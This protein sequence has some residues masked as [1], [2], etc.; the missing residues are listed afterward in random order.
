MI[1]F[2]KPE[3]LRVVEIEEPHPT[4]DEVLIAVRA[5]GVNPSDIGNLAGRFPQ[6]KLPRTPGRDY[7]GV[8]VQGPPELLGKEVWGTGGELGFTRDG[9]HA[10]YV[11][12]PRGAVREKPAILSMEQAAGIG[13]PFVTAWLAVVEAAQVTTGETFVV[14]GS[15]GSVGSAAVQIARW[16]GARTIGVQRGA[17]GSG[18]DVVL[19]SDREDVVKRILELTS[20]RGADACLDAVGG[21]LFDIALASLARGGRLAAI[22]AKGDGRVS[23]DLRD[24]YHRELRLIGVDSLKLDTTGAA[25]VLDELRDG[26]TSLAL[27]P[28]DIQT[29]PLAQASGAYAAIVSGR[30]TGKVVLLASPS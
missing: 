12:A 16:R 13:V 2:G 4:P 7:A 5:A 30:A 27:H 24:F 23:F 9:S 15:R 6:T 3:A 29:Y 10:Q 18:A 20:G 26:F 28:A 19:D 11:V 1:E 21:P 17:M 22:T 14:T 25:K 8:V